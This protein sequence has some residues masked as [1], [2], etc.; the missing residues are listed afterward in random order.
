[1]GKYQD[2]YKTKLEG[3]LVFQD[4]VVDVMFNATGLAIVQYG[5]KAYQDGVGESRTGVEIKHDEMFH[6]T[7][8]LWIE[9]AE[10]SRPREGDYVPSGIFRTDNAWLYIIGDYD[11]IFVF[12]KNMLQGLYHSGRYRTVENRFKTSMGFLMSE[13]DAERYASIIV[14]PKAKEKISKIA[15]DLGELGRELHRIARQDPK[16]LSMF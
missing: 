5:S 12:T 14:K 8:N 11:T 2:Y 1:M 16:Q 9:V 7:G 15:K 6:R 10:K 13:R 3:A 4:F